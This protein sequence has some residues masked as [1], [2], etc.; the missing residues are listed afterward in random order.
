MKRLSI[1]RV[2]MFIAV[3]SL[4]SATTLPHHHHHGD[5]AAIILNS[6]TDHSDDGCQP[7]HSDNSHTCL[8]DEAFDVAKSLSAPQAATLFLPANI[9]H[10]D[11]PNIL[12]HSSTP[13]YA[14]PSDIPLTP[15]P[16]PRHAHRRGPPA[17]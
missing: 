10:S 8:E 17:A 6:L 14:A 16:S 2:V 5:V 9:L 4:L 7:S 13:L 11:I 15:S 3:L 1:I 12:P